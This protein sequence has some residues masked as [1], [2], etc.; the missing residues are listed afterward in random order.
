MQCRCVKTLPCR[1][2]LMN[3]FFTANLTFERGNGS[4]YQSLNTLKSSLP[5]NKCFWGQKKNN[6]ENKSV[7]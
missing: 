3:F 4:I 6:S 2:M 5:H 7:V 1:F